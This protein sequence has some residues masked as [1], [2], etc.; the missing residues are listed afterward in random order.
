M[1]RK[2]KNITIP[3]FTYDKKENNSYF[4][5][6]DKKY[7]KLN[8]LSKDFIEYELEYHIKINDKEKILHNITD[9]IEQLILH[10]KTF[11]ISKK[12]YNEYSNDEITYINKLQKQLLNK[13]LRAITEPSY[14]YKFKL[15]DINNLKIILF[16]KKIFKKYKN[17]IIPKKIYSEEFKQ[18]YYVCLGEY[19]PNIIYALEEVYL[20]SFYYQYGGNKSVGSYNHFHAHEFNEV[21]RDIFNNFDKFKI[22]KFQEEYFSNQELELINKICS[23]LKKLKYKP[24]L[25]KFEESEFEE[26]CYLKDNKKYIKLFI[27]NIKDK[28]KDI[29]YYKELLK[30]HKI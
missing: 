23:K 27:I 30:S 12:Y 18:T 16:N 7:Y 22:H 8:E 10:P 9:V 6:K 21:I 11:K 26:Y 14:N 1:K 24:A 29:K 20:N 13:E 17:T 19:Y 15:K 25:R 2:Y 3:L 5:Y 28:I 4:I